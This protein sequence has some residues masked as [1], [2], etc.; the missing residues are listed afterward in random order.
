M[1][2]LLALLIGVVCGLR[3]L[4]GPALVVW[5][6]HFGWLKLTGSHLAFLANPLSLVIFTVLAVFE[7]IG[8]KT[9]KIPR[10][11]TPGP[12]IWRI[13][14]GGLC[15]AAF[16]IA[17]EASVT[18]SCIL[19]ALGAVAGAFAGYQARHAAAAEG[20][21]PDLP[22]ALLEDLIAIGGGLFLVSRF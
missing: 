7:L 8:D 6:A 10:R 2:F 3:S 17:G 1:V 15:G 11:T 21:L 9:P 14:M 5:G 12:L 4:T 22:V 18:V 16:G 19:G 13:L 20:R